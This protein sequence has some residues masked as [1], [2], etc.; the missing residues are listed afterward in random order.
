MD[1]SLQAKLLRVLQER[2]VERIGSTKI[3][4]LDVR[5]LATTNRN[6]KLEVDNNR[7]REDL[8]YRLNVFPLHWLPLRDRVQDIIPMAQYLINRHWQVEKGP[9][10]ILSDEVKLALESYTWPGN[11][12]EMD[13]VIQRSLI[14]QTG[15]LIQLSDL[16][17]LTDDQTS[18][19]NIDAH[20]RK[21]D[22]NI[23][24]DEDLVNSRKHHEFD[25]IVKVLEDF[26][27]NRKQA[28]DQLGV[29]E[30][31]LRYKLAEMRK[32][33]YGV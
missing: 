5:V 20:I 30:R 14:L 29:S 2:E 21:K 8:Y 1:L 4:P 18:I 7:F 19:C 22:K 11:A 32:E 10:P 6:M 31:T 3:I 12:R 16:Q 26:S 13:N 23:R 9:C 25:L 15:S 17:L 24:I 27:G 33:G 28:S